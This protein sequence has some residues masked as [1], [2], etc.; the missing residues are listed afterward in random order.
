MRKKFGTTLD[1]DLLKR[2][3]AQ[4]AREG[5]QLATLIENAL[6]RYLAETD[7]AVLRNYGALPLS[8]E[9][10]S[11]VLELDPYEPG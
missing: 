4:A 1:S 8:V 6:R 2:A 10:V 11:E 7:S 3:Q 9:Q 5:Q